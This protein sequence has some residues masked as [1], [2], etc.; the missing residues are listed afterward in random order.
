MIGPDG[1]EYPNRGHF[2]AV[3][4]PERLSFGGE[5]PDSPMMSS[6]ETTIEFVALNEH[7]TKVVVSSRM[8]CVDELPE[9]AGAGWNGQ[10]DKLARRLAE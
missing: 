10:L 5:V 4:P 2:G 8:I 6:A 3:E 9:M 1:Q 7:R